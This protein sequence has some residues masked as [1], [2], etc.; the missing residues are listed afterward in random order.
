MYSFMKELSSTNRKSPKKVRRLEKCQEETRE[1]V[2]DPKSAPSN[3]EVRDD[4]EQEGAAERRL[5]FKE[6]LQ[7][8]GGHHVKA[9]YNKCASAGIVNSNNNTKN[10]MQMWKQK[11]TVTTA[12]PNNTGNNTCSSHNTPKQDNKKA[13]NF[14]DAHK[15]ENAEVSAKEVAAPRFVTIPKNI[16]K[17]IEAGEALTDHEKEILDDIQKANQLDTVPSETSSQSIESDGKETAESSKHANNEME[18]TAE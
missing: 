11:T 17:K 18:V 4:A 5:S 10:V 3:E 13:F 9:N 6:R 7:M 14:D 1:Q 8:F 15:G 12:S 16:L 2:E